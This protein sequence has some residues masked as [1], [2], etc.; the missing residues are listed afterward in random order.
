[1]DDTAD[2]AAYNIYAKQLFPYKKGYPLWHPEH[3]KFGEI[4]IGDVGYYRSGAFFRLFNAILPADEPSQQEYGVPEDFIP[5][6]LHKYL[7]NEAKTVIKSHLHS[8]SVD[9]VEVGAKVETAT[10]IVGGGLKVSCERENG[11]FVIVQPEADQLEMHPSKKLTQYIRTSLDS[12]YHFA[13]DVLDLDIAREDILFISGAVKTDNWALGA[14]LRRGSACQISFQA[15]AGS[16]AQGSF[17][18]SKVHE[19]TVEPEWR[20][21]P[22]GAS[23]SPSPSSASLATSPTAVDQSSS[24]MSITS[25]TLKKTPT[26]PKKDQTLFVNYYK[27]KR[28]FFRS[29]IVKAAAGYADLEHGGEGDGEGEL[30]VGGGSDSDV[31]I[32]EFGVDKPYDPVDYLLDYILNYPLEDGSRVD[33]AIAGSTHLYAL[34]DDEFPEDIPTALNK[35]K[36]PIL[37]V[38]DGVAA[39]ACVEWA[40]E[41]DDVEEADPPIAGDVQTAAEEHPSRADD[42]GDEDAHESSKEDDSVDKSSGRAGAAGYYH[43]PL[44]LSEHTGGVTCVAWSPDGRFIASGSE[45]TTIILR[46]GT[47]GRFLH[48]LTEHSDVVWTLAFSP[49]GQ[50][51]ASGASDGLGLIWDVESHSV[52]AVLDGHGSVVQTIQY[53]PGG[54]KIV[55]SSTDFSVRVWDAVTGALVHTLDGHTAVIM[56]AVWSP[57]GKWIASCSADYSAKIWNAETGEVHRTLEGHTGVIWSIAFDPESR[58]VITGSDD[59]TS[60]IWNAETG[61]ALVNLHEHPSPVWAVAFSPDGKRVM[62]ASND[63]T[64]KLC[65]SFTGELV[66]TFDR[67]DALVNAAVFSPDGQY[68]ASSGGDNE[69]LVWDTTTGKRLPAMVGHVDK[70]TALQFSPEGDRLV[71]ASDDGTVRIWTLPEEEEA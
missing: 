41:Y 18:I 39:L 40:E 59:A 11:A 46:D 61:E 34:F 42:L 28:R 14:F 10:E 23:L 67:N 16:F 35:L 24:R 30:M 19:H 60:I 45:D 37:F 36:P 1:M 65:D 56:S 7:L 12:W 66:H 25:L 44:V 5:F 54:S 32:G 52:V 38:D 53:L 20:T 2:I 33:A 26:G 69:V 50:R 47:D 29:R 17:N 62:S 9:T 27:M 51:F 71:S 48:Q 68:V 15:N 4:Q 21:K 22:D 43:A 64:L 55:T 6:Q 49:D 31:S 70:V 57:N 8:K 13:T 63:M 58:R 3:T